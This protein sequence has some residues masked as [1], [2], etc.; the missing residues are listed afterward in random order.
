MSDNEFRLQREVRELRAEVRRLRRTIEGAYFVIGLI[1]VLICPQLL[2]VVAIGAIGYL[3]FLFT[4]LGRKM[5]PHFFHS[6]AEH[7]Y[8]T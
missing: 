2:V 4:P 7:E 1:V 5:F 8:D 6:K 3:A